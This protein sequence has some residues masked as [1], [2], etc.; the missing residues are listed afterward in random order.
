MFVFSDGNRL[1]YHSDRCVWCIG[2]YVGK[3]SREKVTPVTLNIAH[4]QFDRLLEDG[5]AGPGGYVHVHVVLH[6]SCV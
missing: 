1:V 6:V 5:V 2:E 4:N 3:V